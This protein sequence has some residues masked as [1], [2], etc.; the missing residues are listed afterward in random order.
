MAKPI[1]HSKTSTESTLIQY[2][3]NVIKSSKEN[4]TLF[5]EVADKITVLEA[6]L[7]DYT[8]LKTEASFRDIRQV[9]NKNQQATILK[10]ALY[11]LSLH[12]ESAAKGD[13][14]VIL[15][16]G[17]ML[18][19]NAAGT[20]VGQ[21][22]KPNDLRALVTHPGT[23]TVQLRV[24]PWKHSRLYQFEYRKANSMNEWTAVLSTKSRL[25][26]TALEYLQEYEFRVTYLGSTPTPNYS[27]IVRCAVV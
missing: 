26:I 12:I 27:E 8:D 20:S 3:T 9:A 2:A 22:P 18:N 23:N 15:A 21:S 19:K 16:A 6:A 7:A 24:A 4:A 11:D 25:A 17:F 13:P 1:L 5:P 14:T 10:Q